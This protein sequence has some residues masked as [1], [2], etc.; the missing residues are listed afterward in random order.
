MPT[1]KHCLTYHCD[2]KP[3]CYTD[4]LPHFPKENTLDELLVGTSNWTYPDMKAVQQSINESNFNMMFRASIKYTRYNNNNNNNIIIPDDYHDV[5][6][7]FAATG[8]Y[9]GE[10]HLKINIGEKDFI[11]LF[12][13]Y[14]GNKLTKVFHHHH[15]HIYMLNVF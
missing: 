8:P 4:Y 2:I 14:T 5:K 10:I 15:H 9:A 12:S 11:W 1:P 6:L 13:E 7:N 3:L